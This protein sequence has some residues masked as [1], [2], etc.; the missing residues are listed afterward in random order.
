MS[1]FD[2]RYLIDKYSTTFT[3]IIPAVGEYN[4]S[5]DWVDG[6]EQIQEMVGAIIAH[7]ESKIFQSGGTITQQDKAL[8]ILEPITDALKRSRIIYDGKEYRIGDE[9]EN[10]KFTNVWGYTLK[11]VSVFDNGGGG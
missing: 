4:D 2:F 6:T 5:G 11:Y 8:F 9:L 7:R 1:F 3:A 10:S